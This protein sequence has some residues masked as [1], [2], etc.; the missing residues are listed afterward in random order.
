MT[1]VII[2]DGTLGRDAE[3]KVTPTGKAV[4]SFSIAV[5]N[6]FGQNKKEPYWFNIVCW[7][8][9]AE[10]AGKLTKGQKVTVYG[11]LTS[12]KYKNKAGVDVTVTEVVANAISVRERSENPRPAQQATPVDDSDPCPF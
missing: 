3:Y 7:Q 10:F 6:G 8:E 4:T 9:L 12:R 2:L 11:R 5:D 1:N